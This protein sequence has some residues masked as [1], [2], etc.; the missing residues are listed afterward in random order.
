VVYNN[1]TGMIKHRICPAEKYQP[2][3]RKSS[4]PMAF[5]CHNDMS[6]CD[7]EGE[8]RCD[9][10]S[11]DKDRTCGCDYRSGYT[12]EAL[13]YENEQ[14]IAC[15]SPLQVDLMCTR[16]AM[17]Q[18]TQELNKYYQCVTECPTGFYRPDGDG[19]HPLPANG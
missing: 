10:G 19:C 11:S 3:E 4:D 17:C 15:V 5:Q 12:L 7:A 14:K 16:L 6:P 9:N 2:T 18:S 1:V 13:A 8:I